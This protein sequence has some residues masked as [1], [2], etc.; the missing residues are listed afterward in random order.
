MTKLTPVG[1]LGALLIFTACGPAEPPPPAAQ[2]PDGLVRLTEEQ[3]AVAGVQVEPVTI[4]SVALQIDIPATVASPDTA[5][6]AVGSLVEGRV[7]SVAVLPGDEVVE[8]APLIYLHSHELTDALRDL[9]AAE[10][11]LSFADAALLRSD[12][13]L[14]AGAV[15]REEAE[16]R[17]AERDAIA[18]D[19]A[20]AQEWVGHLSPDDEGH[21]VMRAPRPGVVFEVFAHP[22][23]GVTPGDPLVSLG[24][25]DV[26]WVTGWMP[27]Q[28][29]LHVGPGDEVS[30]R[31]QALP[32]HEVRAH[33]V[34]MGGAVDPVRRAVEVRAELSWVPK[35]VRPGAFATLLLPSTS[36][37]LRAM[38]PSDAVQRLGGAE[39][40]FVEEGRGLYRPI[41]VTSHTLPD[42]RVTVE[43]L[44][45]GQRVVVAGA[46]AVRS[47]MENAAS[48]EDES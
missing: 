37:E 30:V 35:G 47:V 29:S 19:V 34:R 33:V 18:A 10:A 40:V 44:A 48:A 9:T 25:T 2:A 1:A 15:A 38:V 11:R 20:R 3:M 7:E 14:E 12:Q 21:V 26:L 4:Q 8:G 31:F 46:Y 28:E 43:G 17:K 45:E 23:A 6:A 42:G 41:T 36:Q 39:V 32:G 16:R 13:L 5:L 27:E 24:R 22:G